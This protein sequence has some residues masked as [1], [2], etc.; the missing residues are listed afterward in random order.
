MPTIEKPPTPRQL[1]FVAAVAELARDA[2][3]GPSLQEIAAR[4][5]VSVTRAASL[6]AECKSRGLVSHEPRVP[7]SWR[8]TASP[9]RRSR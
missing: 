8:V 3:Y 4:L 1:D 9:R 7:R 5:R 2:G 6:G